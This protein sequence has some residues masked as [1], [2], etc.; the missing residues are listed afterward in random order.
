MDSISKGFEN[1]SLG[2]ISAELMH[3]ISIEARERGFR[4]PEFQVFK[5]TLA[6]R[7]LAKRR[8]SEPS[9]VVPA[10]HRAWLEK[11]SR[12]LLDEVDRRRATDRW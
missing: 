11:R 7:V 6:K 2:A 3:R 10:E 5:R 4:P 12:E 9:I 8:R 1:D